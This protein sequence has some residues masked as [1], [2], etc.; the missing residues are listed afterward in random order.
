MKN[1]RFNRGELILIAGITLVFAALSALGLRAYLERDNRWVHVVSPT[2]AR[3]VETVAVSRL[4]QPYVRTDQGTYFFCSGTT[5]RDTCEPIDEAR[6]PAAAVPPRWQMCEPDLPE[7]PAP[8]GEVVHSLDFARCQ[9]ARTYARLII[10]ADG[11]IWRWQRS[12]SWVNGFA[13]ASGVFWSLVL[14]MLVGI[15][16]VRVQRYLN[17]PIPGEKQGA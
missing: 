4:L 3:A 17:S 9:E 11:S 5:W 7:L 10:L 13:F 15:G 1:T 2:E 16:A 12:F 6:L 8:P 14:G